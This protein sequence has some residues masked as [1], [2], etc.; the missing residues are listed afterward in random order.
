MQQQQ[1][2]HRK[3]HYTVVTDSTIV[4]IVSDHT[5]L[6]TSCSKNDPNSHYCRKILEQNG[7]NSSM[8]VKAQK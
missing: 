5:A 1:Q 6:Q 4:C 7:L 2:M 8:I 3:W